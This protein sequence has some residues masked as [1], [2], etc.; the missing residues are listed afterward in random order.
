M[1]G[2][3]PPSPQGSP[4]KTPTPADLP[5]Y[6]EATTVQNQQQ[7][8]LVPVAATN[9]QE[10]VRTATQDSIASTGSDAD[11]QAIPTTASAKIARLFQ[12]HGRDFTA[13]DQ[14]EIRWTID[15]LADLRT[16]DKVLSPPV[17]CFGREWRI[18]LFPNGNGRSMSM[19]MY[20]Q[21]DWPDK[22]DDEAVPADFVLG[23]VN[24]EDESIS[25][26]QYS[27]H[28]FGEVEMDW[29]F[30]AFLPLQELPKFCQRT[31]VPTTT[32]SQDTA[33]TTSPTDAAATTPPPTNATA[34]TDPA[35]P[36]TTTLPT[37]AD[38]I[39]P[40]TSSATAT[41]IAAQH[42]FAQKT[43][44]VAHVRALYDETGVLFH[45][46][47]DYNSK[48]VT[49]YVGLK[50]Q[51][52]TCYMNSILQSL[53]CTNYFRKAVYQIPP[54]ST[55]ATAV[56]GS[57]A[58]STTDMLS[59]SQ[60]GSAL[61]SSSSASNG[62]PQRSVTRALQR[63]FYFMQTASDAVETNELTKSF[64]WNTVDAFAQHDVQEFL[65]VLSDNLE[66]KMKG[67][68]ADGMIQWLFVGK[69]KSYIKCVNVEYESARVE[70]FYDVQ[71]N[72]KGMKSV[73]DSFH[74]YIQVEMLEGDNKYMAEGHGL[75][76]A[77]KGVVF[78]Q[79]PPVLHLQLKRFEYDFMRDAM[80][81]I[82]DR[83][84]F[85][86]ELDLDEFLM[87]EAGAAAA[88]PAVPI[89]QKY[90][91]HGVL[92][93]S[94]SVDAGHYCAF[95]RPSRANKWFKFDDDKVV[96]VTV[97]EVTEDNYGGEY[98]ARPGARGPGA[99]GPMSRT[100]IHKRFTNAYMLV[101]IREADYDKVLCDV[102]EDDVPRVIR[103]QLE[104]ERL[105]REAKERELRERE[106]ML[107]VRIIDDATIKAHGEFDLWNFSPSSTEW[108]KRL[109]K[110]ETKWSDVHAMYAREHLGGKPLDQVRFWL[111]TNRENK[112]LRPDSENLL[113]PEDG[114]L[115]LKELRARNAN[116]GSPY[117]LLV[118]C[119]VPTIP[120]GGVD[121]TQLFPPSG[122]ALAKAGLKAG[123]AL[124]F[125]KVFDV[126]TQTMRIVGHMHVDRNAVIKDS[127]PT[128]CTLAGL[129]V[130]TKLRVFEEVHQTMQQPMNVKSTWKAE[131]VVDGDIIAVQVD[132]PAAEAGLGETPA[133]AVPTSPKTSNHH[134]SATDA[135]SPVTT[136]PVAG[137]LRTVLDYYEF[138]INR[139]DVVFKPKP[140]GRD[141]HSVASPVSVTAPTLPPE[142]RLTLSKKMT[143][144]EVSARVAREL[145]LDDPFKV[146]F[147]STYYNDVPKAVLRRVPNM[148]LADM[149]GTLPMTG[150]YR[151]QQQQTMA[152]GAPPAGTLLYEI[153]PMSLV[154]MEQ[155]R[156]LKVTCVLPAK[157]D[158]HLDVM[159]AKTATMKQLAQHVAEKLAGSIGGASIN[160]DAV[161][162]NE[163]MGSRL[164]RE[165]DGKE[166]L[167]ML[168]EYVQ[169]VAQIMPS[170]AAGASV[171]HHMPVVHM[172][173]LP[174]Q[175]HG[176]PFRF[177][178]VKGEK[179]AA[180]RARLQQYL[181]WSDKEMGKV[182]PLK[183]VA[184][185]AMEEVRE[186][187]D[188]E[189]VADLIV[190][191]PAVPIV[192]VPIVDPAAAEDQKADENAQEKQS[193]KP[194]PSP[195][196][197]SDDKPLIHTHLLLAL[198]H[199]VRRPSRFV[200]GLERAVKIFN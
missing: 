102:T 7:M 19:S 64:G 173:K 18:L 144:D 98:P 200:S 62:N 49:G 171:V 1:A 136:V 164:H 124:L 45:S 130:G 8:A 16:Q 70:D 175:L 63:L 198:D 5:S 146:R 123:T 185:G 56:G 133:A 113:S 140:P 184:V 168:P 150:F 188:D 149:V 142:L 71:L 23:I 72:V 121:G 24:P 135:T 138:L 127:L 132:T 78:T 35:S 106:F 92:V 95:I 187:A 85:P 53:F 47:K 193:P 28:R 117:E 91:L 2:I 9:P 74:D 27:S 197:A 107:T 134:L 76:D 167:S 84:E 151:N 22:K 4:G 141:N 42:G 155:K 58:G 181:G 191:K 40:R 14:A 100:M 183:V 145:G 166:P 30:S 12:D 196:G 17:K 129:P 48:R 147:T 89:K 137:H 143:Y 33:A 139:M 148:L 34:T 190:V 86:L 101:Y 65:R 182:T 82:N 68:P 186:L 39:T 88:D 31:P 13:E 67:T 169:L 116:S 87:P 125:V 180:M 69:M 194:K 126:A 10:R 160:P 37:T 94:G 192:S 75:Q 83:Y 157:H 93:H 162:I 178:V 59:N 43:T 112:S 176:T 179:V 122:P 153:L 177:P 61:E 97:K 165:F 46:F 174:T 36:P 154:E 41:P 119:E 32:S 111:L 50:N 57:E 96:P 108:Q 163:V 25:H 54:P 172:N 73:T 161:R 152:A 15:S 66:E 170:V 118:Y 3:T 29:G 99:M 81:K 104:Q 156:Q 105:E 110:N 52:A 115:S 55:S 199:P 20:L 21:L 51:G 38:V 189:C 77:K 131:E 26:F 44:L 79:F 195:V 109:D 103:D 90:H 80:V 128:V 6:E 120:W 11:V 60:P 158:E 159:I 114:E